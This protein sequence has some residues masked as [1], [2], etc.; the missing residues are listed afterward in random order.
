MKSNIVIKCFSEIKKKDVQISKVSLN[1]SYHF[2]DNI[3][4]YIL[5][6]LIYHCLPQIT[7]RT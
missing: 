1:Y 5:F 4:L 6:F 7:Q 3:F 2:H